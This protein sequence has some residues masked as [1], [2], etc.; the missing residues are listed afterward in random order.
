M[1]DHTDFILHLAM[2]NEFSTTLSEPVILQDGCEKWRRTSSFRPSVSQANAE[3]RKH[4]VYWFDDG[5]LVLHIQNTLF[6]VHLSLLKRHSPYLASLETTNP[7]IK[8]I[9]IINESST[10]VMYVTL[11]PDRPVNSRDVEALLEHMYHDW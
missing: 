7:V 1:P 8:P 10:P 3:L 5:L 9:P 6:R 2:V 11:G 4:P